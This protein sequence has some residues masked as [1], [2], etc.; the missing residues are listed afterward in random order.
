MVEYLGKVYGDIGYSAMI[1]VVHRHKHKIIVQKL[2]L[3]VEL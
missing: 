1:A 2:T 3:V